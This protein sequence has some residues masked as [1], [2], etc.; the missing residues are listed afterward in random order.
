MAPNEDELAF[1]FDER[2]GATEAELDTA[3]R[4]VGYV[5]PKP[6]RDLLRRQNGGVSNFAGYEVEGR[7]YP[8]LP[9]LGVDPDAAAGTL[10]RAHDVRVHFGV[11][12]GVVVIAAQGSAW[13]GLDYNTKRDC[14]SV[15]YRADEGVAPVEVALSFEAFLSHLTE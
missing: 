6:F 12:D 7:Y 2:R 4:Y 1:W 8:M 3:E 10:M 13:W 14:P 11:P 9:I 15:V 5:L